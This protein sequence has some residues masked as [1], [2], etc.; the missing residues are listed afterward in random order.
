MITSELSRQ[1]E[2][3]RSARIPDELPT[4]KELLRV[5][6]WD[7]VHDRERFDSLP[8]AEGA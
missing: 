3:S 8:K 6:G 5:R 4:P 7:D 1:P 2:V